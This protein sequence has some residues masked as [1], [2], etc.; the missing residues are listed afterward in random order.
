MLVCEMGAVEKPI[1]CE[2]VCM[3]DETVY[4]HGR[5]AFVLVFFPAACLPPYLVV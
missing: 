5:P 3:C 4:L 1:V 2:T